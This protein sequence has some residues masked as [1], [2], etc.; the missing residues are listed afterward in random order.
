[1]KFL[2][3]YFKFI[4]NSIIKEILLNLHVPLII[5]IEKKK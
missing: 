5:K 1:M 4:D 2:F 3:K